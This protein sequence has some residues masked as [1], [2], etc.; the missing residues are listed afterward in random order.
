V[1]VLFAVAESSDAAEYYKGL[2]T[3]SEDMKKFKHLR[4]NKPTAV[5]FSSWANPTKLGGELRELLDECPF[6]RVSE[7]GNEVVCTSEGGVN[8]SHNTSVAML[9]IAV[10]MSEVEGGMYEC[11]FFYDGVHM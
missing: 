1:R 9:D 2:S 5:E 7:C 6:A 3:V 10:L 11:S 4:G 8:W